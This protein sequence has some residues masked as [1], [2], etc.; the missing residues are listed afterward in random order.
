MRD[1]KSSR[2]ATRL[3]ANLTNLEFLAETYETANDFALMYEAMLADAR[4]RKD[5]VLV[6]KMRRLLMR[7]SRYL[8]QEFKKA[9]KRFEFDYHEGPEPKAEAIQ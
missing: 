7:Q 2:G 4:R 3:P 9:G 5:L 6:K 8:I 1:E